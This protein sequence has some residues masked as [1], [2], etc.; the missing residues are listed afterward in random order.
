MHAQASAQQTINDEQAQSLYKFNKD[1]LLTA[2]RFYSE[3]AQIIVS[4]DGEC[5]V[6]SNIS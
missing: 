2:A 6:S 5:S 4:A 1:I 3:V